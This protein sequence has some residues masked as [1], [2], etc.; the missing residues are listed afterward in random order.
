MIAAIDLMKN[1]HRIF[2]GWI[3]TNG[4]WTVVSL[5]L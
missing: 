2:R 4:N 5:L 3:M 1:S